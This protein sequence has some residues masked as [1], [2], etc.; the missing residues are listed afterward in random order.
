MPTPA[1]IR[2]AIDDKLLLL[3][4]SI[5]TKET[6]YALTHNGRYWQGLITRSIL[7]ADGVSELPDVGTKT[8]TDQPDPWP[9]AL[10]NTT[11]SLP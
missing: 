2:K 1:Q 9:P 7:P 11:S 8:P 3:W 6:G 10:R 5:Q 4:T